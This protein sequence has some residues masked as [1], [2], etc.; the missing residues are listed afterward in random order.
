MAIFEKDMKDF[1]KNTMVMF[2]PIM[3]ILLATLYSRFN[4]GVDGVSYEL[5]YI[6]IGITFS[7]V[8]TGLMMMIMAEEK[9]KNTLRGL[10]MSP[11]SFVDIIVGKSLVT[12]LLTVVTFVISFLIFDPSSLV[13]FSVILSS[14]LLFV[15]FLLL[16]I[17]VGLFVKSVGTTTIYT[18]PIMLIFGFT[19]MF[20]M[21]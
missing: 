12:T 16:G 21:L 8:S 20:S 6:I 2:T 17:G 5:I 10:M 1:T 4:D 13:D 14:L 9:E 3:P 18:L 11:A 7:T 19:T 15:F